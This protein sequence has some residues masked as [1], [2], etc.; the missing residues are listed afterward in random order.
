MYGMNS[1]LE[2]KPDGTLYE[3]V[4]RSGGMYGRQIDRIIAALRDAIPYAEN[5]KQVITFE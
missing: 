3:N 4:W 2:K 1:R 5:K